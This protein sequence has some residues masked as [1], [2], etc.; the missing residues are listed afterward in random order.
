[1]GDQAIGGYVRTHSPRVCRYERNRAFAKV[2]DLQLLFYSQFSSDADSDVLADYV[3]ALIRSDAPDEEIRQA[4]IENL[5]DFLK[6][7]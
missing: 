6:E 5:E 2:N 7:S 3:L 1:L 4:S